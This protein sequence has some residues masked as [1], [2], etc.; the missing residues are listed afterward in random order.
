MTTQMRPPTPARRPP[1]PPTTQPAT[2]FRFAYS[3]GRIEPRCP[4]VSIDRE[5]AQAMGALG[6]VPEGDRMRQVLTAPSNQ[7]L[8]RNLCWVFS[9]RGQDAFVVTPAD[10]MDWK[11]LPETLGRE[12][13]DWVDVVIGHLGPSAGPCAAL[14]LPLLHFDCLYS[15]TRAQLLEPLDELREA[16]KL[17]AEQFNRAFDQLIAL[18]EDSLGTTDADRALNYLVL[19]YP[20]IYQLVTERLAAGGTLESVKVRPSPLGEHRRIVDVVLSFLDG[21]DGGYSRHYM[22]VDV[23]EEFPFLVSGVA[24]Y[25]EH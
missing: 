20:E 6:E 18:T 3:F 2:P 4:Q 11:L 22:R 16:R 19:R 12:A 17:P 13:A 9:V 24:P 7:Y 23:T 14:G 10:P 21:R 15:F 25:V 5:I 8:V 1:T